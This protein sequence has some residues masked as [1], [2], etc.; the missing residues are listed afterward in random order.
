MHS[1]PVQGFRAAICAGSSSGRAAASQAAGGGF[2]ARP[3]LQPRKGFVSQ[4]Y[5]PDPARSL[6]RAGGSLR[7]SGLL[8]GSFQR[9]G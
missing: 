9:P 4:G 1:G 3:A 6:S 8:C 7:R 5:K 2:E